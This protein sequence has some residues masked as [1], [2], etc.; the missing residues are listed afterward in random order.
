VEKVSDS[1]IT[2]KAL[3]GSI[4]KLMKNYP[5]KKISIKDIVE[6]CNLNRQSFYYHFRDKYDLVNW[7]YYTEFVVRIKKEKLS[8]WDVMLEACKYFYNNLDFY[9]N[10]FRETGQNSF[11]EYFIEVLHPLITANLHDTFDC[12]GYHDF[13]CK[14]YEDAI[15][16]SISRWLL[17]GAIIPPEQYIELLKNAIEIAAKNLKDKDYAV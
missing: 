5:L 16:A 17:D 4:K 11:S 6:G 7:I 10:A 8:S 13:Y 15:Q 3:A 12:Q 1:Y 14:F 2:K 9:K